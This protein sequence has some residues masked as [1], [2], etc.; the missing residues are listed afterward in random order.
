MKYKI[1]LETILIIILIGFILLPSI[2]AIKYCSPYHEKEI[3]ETNARIDDYDIYRFCYVESGDVN[4]DHFNFYK[5]GFF[6][7]ASPGLGIGRVGVYLK[8]WRGNTRLKVENIFGTTSYNYDV[9]VFVRGFIGYAWPTVSIYGGILKGY[10][11][12]A[13]IGPIE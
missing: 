12:L 11:I 3:S 6:W 13:K 5:R 10:A 9:K 8:D 7:P 1:I 4:H 2:N